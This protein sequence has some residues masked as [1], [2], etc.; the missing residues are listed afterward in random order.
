M[1]QKI[2]ANGLI[3]IDLVLINISIIAAYLLRF[4]LFSKNW[5]LLS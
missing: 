2:R 4:G 1:K 3:A 5:T